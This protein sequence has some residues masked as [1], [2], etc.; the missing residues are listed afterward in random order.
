MRKKARE[1]ELEQN[2]KTLQSFLASKKVD[3]ERIECLK[4]FIA[5]RQNM[6]NTSAVAF[7]QDDRGKYIGDQLLSDLVVDGQHSF[8]FGTSGLDCLVSCDKKMSPVTK[9]RYLDQ[10]LR[11]K[12]FESNE[13]SFSTFFAYEVQGGVDGIAMSKNGSCFAQLDFVLHRT[14]DSPTL[15]DEPMMNMNE[16]KSHKTVLFKILLK[17]QFGKG[18]NASKLAS[19]QWIILEDRCVPKKA[20]VF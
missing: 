2:Q 8:E 18:E 20:I 14:E 19:M 6:M 15:L 16:I 9:M 17:A 5:A 3:S 13:I 11:K 4:H 7:Q 12:I 1:M 10:E